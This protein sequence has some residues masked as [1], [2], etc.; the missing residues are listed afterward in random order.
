MP[1]QCRVRIGSAMDCKKLLPKRA[2]RFCV[3][4]ARRATNEPGGTRILKLDFL[5]RDCAIV[6]RLLSG[7]LTSRGLQTT[8]IFASMRW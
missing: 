3:I 2:F 5:Q 4:S 7:R 1:R 8:S 6:E